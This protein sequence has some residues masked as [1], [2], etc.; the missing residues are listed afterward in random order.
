MSW[1]FSIGLMISA[2]VVIVAGVILNYDVK[3]NVSGQA[4]PSQQ[5]SMKIIIGFA[6]WI[7][8][9]ILLYHFNFRALGS[10][11]LWIA[12]IPALAIALLVLILGIW[13]PKDFK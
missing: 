10:I 12:I 7:G 6:I 4:T 3:H 8:V 2:L 11:L 9:C 1:T 13:G 5:R